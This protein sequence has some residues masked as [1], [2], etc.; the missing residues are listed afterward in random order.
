[1]KIS[2]TCGKNKE[3][4]VTDIA[5]S[6]HKHYTKKKTLRTFNAEKNIVL[7]FAMYITI[8]VE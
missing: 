2:F 8:Y 5:R 4:S 6:N 3:K 7:P 1:M